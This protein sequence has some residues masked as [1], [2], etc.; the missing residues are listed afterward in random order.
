MNENAVMY[1]KNGGVTYGENEVSERKTHLEV[2]A[3]RPADAMHTLNALH[4]PPRCLDARLLRR[5]FRLLIDG[6]RRPLP[7]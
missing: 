1:R 7:L 4:Y 2:E 5:N 6:E 3:G